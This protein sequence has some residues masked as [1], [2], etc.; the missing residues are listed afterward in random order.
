MRCAT[1]ACPIIKSQIETYHLMVLRNELSDDD[2]AV[3]LPLSANNCT[4][5]E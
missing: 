1:A 4:A 3:R 2:W 5:K